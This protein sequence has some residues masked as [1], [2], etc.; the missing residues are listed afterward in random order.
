MDGEALEALRY[1]S[2]ETHPQS[3]VTLAGR[4]PVLL[5]AP[6]AV[7]QTRSG[8]LKAAERYTGMLCL[9][10]NRRYDVPCIYKSRHL[11][12][13]ANHD[14]A[15][16]YRDEVCRLIRE[17]GVRFVLDLHQLRPDRAMALCIGTGWGRHL[18]ALSDAPDVVRGA[19]ARRGLLPVT[20]DDPFSAAAAHTVSA[21][22]AR[23]EAGAMQLEINSALLMEDSPGERFGD[24]LAALAEAVDGL[25]AM[26]RAHGES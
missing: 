11:M 17:E 16:P 15:S 8:R 21:T 14:P 25:S 18:H 5:S 10:L 13:D 26:L 9:L 24:V 20:L 22:A 4:G 2:D 7:L 6:H 3:F 1:F 19:F 12:D 23:A